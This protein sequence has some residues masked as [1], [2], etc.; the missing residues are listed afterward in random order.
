MKMKEKFANMENKVVG[1]LDGHKDQLV[2][3]QASICAIQLMA[4]QAL[5]GASQN[6]SNTGTDIFTRV[7][8]MMGT[9]Y[10]AIAGISSVTAGCVAAVCLYLMFFSKNQQTVDSSIQWLKRILICWLAIMLMSTIIYFIVKN[11]GIGD[12]QSLTGW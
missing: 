7:S 4:M 3:A 11:M 5:A 8:N 1:Y 9:I 6:S 10:S 2:K 12:S